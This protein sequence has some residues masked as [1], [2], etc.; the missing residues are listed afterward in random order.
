MTLEIGH[1]RAIRLFKEEKEVRLLKLLFR[2]NSNIIG[3]LVIVMF[4]NVEHFKEK[5]FGFIQ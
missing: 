3:D 5:A 1:A 2:S 4:G